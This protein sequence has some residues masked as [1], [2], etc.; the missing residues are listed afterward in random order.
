[1][2]PTRC[3]ALLHS[4]GYRSAVTGGRILL[5][6]L[7]LLVVEC[8]AFDIRISGNV[9]V[10]FAVVGGM[11]LSIVTFYSQLINGS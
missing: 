5:V 11:V 3:N 9:F 10:V 1:M 7:S 2:I 4:V 6:L 8:D